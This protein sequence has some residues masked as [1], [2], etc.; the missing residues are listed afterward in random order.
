[1]RNWAQSPTGLVSGCCLAAL[2]PHP[3]MD[4]GGL[5]H[6][7]WVQGWPGTELPLTTRRQVCQQVSSWA[8]RPAGVFYRTWRVF[9]FISLCWE[10]ERMCYSGLL[11]KPKKFRAAKETWGYQ[12]SPSERTPWR[13]VSLGPAGPP[14]CIWSVMTLTPCKIER[15]HRML[16]DLT[17][18]NSPW[19]KRVMIKIT[20]EGNHDQNDHHSDINNENSNSD[21]HYILQRSKWSC[22]VC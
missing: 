19:E 9:P 20:G 16:C 13:T 2:L 22:G 6:P 3:A 8:Y 4:P 12:K 14:V 11:I 7:S 1:M 10:K 17:H 21:R 5:P 15:P 18:H